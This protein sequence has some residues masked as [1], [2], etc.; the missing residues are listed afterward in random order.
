[1]RT[2][3][4]HGLVATALEGSR[5]HPPQ[6]MCGLPCGERRHD[7][8]DDDKWYWIQDRRFA[9]LRRT[10]A[11]AG[12]GA[13]AA[14]SLREEL[15]RCGRADGEAADVVTAALVRR[16]AKL[17]MMPEDDVDAGKPLSAYGVDSLVA[18]EVRNYLSKEMAVD[19]SVFDIMA[20]VP[21]RQLAADLAGK[22]K[23]LVQEESP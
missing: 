19:V 7:D 4:L 2:S 6:V 10:A 9:N 3:D 8:D 1:M 11:G 16:L 13:S 18:V 21:M 23:L 5:A 20:N 12:A 15:V 22:S 14:V 17:M